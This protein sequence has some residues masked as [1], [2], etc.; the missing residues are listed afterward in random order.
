VAVTKSFREL[1]LDIN[2]FSSSTRA[3]IDGQVPASLNYEAWLRKQSVERQNDVLGVKKAVLFRNGELPL[4]RFISKQG[5]EY[6][7]NELRLRDAESF[8]LAGL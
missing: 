5:H 7:L 6:S 1:G 8:K 4:S 3:S 2:E